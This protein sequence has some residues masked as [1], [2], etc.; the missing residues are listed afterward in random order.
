LLLG[1]AGA[2]DKGKN[3]IA[4]DWHLLPLSSSQLRKLQT[5]SPPSPRY[6]GAR[7]T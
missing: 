3:S 4:Q 2:G 5:G 6:R 1:S 7:S